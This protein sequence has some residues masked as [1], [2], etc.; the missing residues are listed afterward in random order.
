MAHSTLAATKLAAAAPVRE[1]AQALGVSERT[2]LAWRSGAKFP[3][4]AHRAE[5]RD[6]F[7]VPL[8]AWLQRPSTTPAARVAAPA[9]AHVGAPGEPRGEAPATVDA[10]PR[11]DGTERPR[12]LPLP[13]AP[14]FA[15]DVLDTA[16]LVR[17]LIAD[18]KGPAGRELDMMTRGKLLS[19]AT[20]TLQRLGGRTDN[21][22]SLSKEAIQ[23]S[24]SWTGLLVGLERVLEPFPEALRALGADL[25]RS[26]NE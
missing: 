20:Q 2:V 8:E 9:A 25:A 16:Q 26:Y 12:F 21:L 7:A 6:R 5:L 3:S 14:S 17:E 4:D 19:Q 11:T 13:E 15:H 22:D 10:A 24:P 1:V 18:L 23:G